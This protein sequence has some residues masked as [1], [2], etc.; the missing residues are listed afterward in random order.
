VHWGGSDAC[1]GVTTYDV[2]YNTGG[3]AWQP[4][5]TGT[6][7]TNGAFDPASPQYGQAYYFHV[8]AHDLAGNTGAWSAP[9]GTLL[10]QYKLSGSILTVREQPIAGA[11][12]TL[13]PA[14]LALA[15]RPGGYLAYLAGE[16]VYDVWAGRA[17]FDALPPML[18]VTVAGDVSG[19]DLFLPPLDDTVANGGFEAGNLDA[20]QTG[21]TIS[22]TLAAAAHTGAHS[23][24][25]GD[26]AGRSTISQVVTLPL[27]VSDPT[28]SFLVRLEQPGSPSGLQVVLSGA[29]PVT[30]SLLVESD[31][32][33]H[34][35]YDLTGLVGSPLTVTFVASGSPPALIDEISLG[36]AVRGGYWVYLPLATRGW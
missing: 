29:S 30:H 34:V 10:A 3:G 25:L 1:S 27:A 19:I 7:S 24:K 13:N 20:W 36:S 23:V 28:V 35:W 15:P 14:A 17:G 2:E 8:R 11:L 32:W 18:D 5:L 4:W 21:G 31:A 9:V 22:P 6:S 26:V 12:V 16:G 33:S